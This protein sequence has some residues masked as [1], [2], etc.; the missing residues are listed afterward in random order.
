MN[1]IVDFIREKKVNW[2]Y[3]TPAYIRTIRPADVPGLELLL[4]CGE[5]LSQDIFELW[6]GKL[7][8]INGW[9]PA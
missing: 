5:A 7:R 2:A 3:L 1:G 4:L 8:L 6:F 9:G